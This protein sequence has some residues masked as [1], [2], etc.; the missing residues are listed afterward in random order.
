MQNSPEDRNRIDEKKANN[1]K[2]TEESTQHMATNDNP[3]ANE[4]IKNAP[5]DKEN[6]HSEVGSEIT[7]GEGG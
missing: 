2:G 5:F 3:R 6:G 4:N 1:E 7:D